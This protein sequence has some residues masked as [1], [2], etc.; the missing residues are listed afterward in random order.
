[1]QNGG[2]MMDEMQNEMNHEGEGAEQH[3]SRQNMCKMRG[4]MMDQL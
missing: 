1:V 2:M 3:E 4:I